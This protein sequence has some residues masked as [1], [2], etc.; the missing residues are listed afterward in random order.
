MRPLIALL[1]TLAA[2]VPNLARASET[3]VGDR[4]AVSISRFSLAAGAGYEWVSAAGDE[5]APTPLHEWVVGIYGAYNLFSV[6][7]GPGR[8]SLIGSI[9]YPVDSKLVRS[10]IGIRISIFTGK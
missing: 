4:P 9:A 7:E 3:V 2:F 5:P 8:T 1:L 10:Q 6:P